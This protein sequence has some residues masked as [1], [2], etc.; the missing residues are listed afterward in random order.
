MVEEDSHEEFFSFAFSGENN[1]N[2]HIRAPSSFSSSFSVPPD[3][4]SNLLIDSLTKLL[5]KWAIQST[6]ETR[7]LVIP[8][9]YLYTKQFISSS[10]SFSWKDY[11]KG[12]DRSLA[13]AL[14]PPRRFLSAYFTLLQPRHQHLEEEEEEEEEEEHDD[15]D[16][17]VSDNILLLYVQ[18]STNIP[19]NSLSLSH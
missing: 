18:C 10:S 8:L 9:R 14:L 6:A 16:V 12:S 11:L 17:E 3:S 13:D 1:N 19:S 2:T 5:G 7:L 4:S 15:D